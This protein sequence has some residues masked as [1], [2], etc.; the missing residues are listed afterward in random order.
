VELQHFERRATPRYTIP[1]RVLLVPENG[2]RIPALAVNI[3]SS[4]MLV[5]P[6]RPFRVS[7]GESITV[8]V[9][10]PG[11]CD[12]ALSTWGIGIVV[13]VDENGT[14]IH[15]RAGSFCACAEEV[16]DC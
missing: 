5:H 16:A 14:A 10:L 13:R 8:E 9:E 3:S 4:G 11:G 15:L 1:A 7:P 2:P 6:D 12:K